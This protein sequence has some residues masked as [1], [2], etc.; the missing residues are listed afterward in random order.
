MKL[1]FHLCVCVRERDSERESLRRTIFTAMLC[2]SELGSVSLG[3]SHLAECSQFCC[4]CHHA[5]QE[6]STPL[7]E[8]IVKELTTIS[9][10]LLSLIFFLREIQICCSVVLSIVIS[11][12][13]ITWHFG[14]VVMKECD[15]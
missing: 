6:I 5:Y 1:C 12:C 4:C 14:T 3:L 15:I 2:V 10:F 9:L 11:F 7:D 13:V 8:V